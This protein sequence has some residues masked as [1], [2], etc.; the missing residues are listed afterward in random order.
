MGAVASAVSDVVGGAV[1]TV[2]DAVEDVGDFVVNEV[3]EPVVKTVDNTIQAALEDPVGT[4]VKVAAISTGNPAIIAAANA[5][6]AVAN[7]ASLEDAAKAGATGYVAGLVGQQVATNLSPEFTSQFENVAAGNAAAN[8]IGNAA[9]AAVSGRDPLAALITSGAGSAA[10]EIT[11][12]MEGFDQLSK[13]QQAAV[14][15]AIAK[16]LTGRDPSQNLIN[17]AI[18]AGIDA[19]DLE[20]FKNTGD[21]T[22]TTAAPSTDLVNQTINDPNAAPD[23]SFYESIGIDPATLS[24]PP[25]A[26]ED[27]LAFL[28]AS[29]YY[30][31]ITGQFIYDENGPLQAPLDN[32]SGTN[33]DSMDGYTYDKEKRTWVSP[34]GSVTDLS[35]LESSGKPLDIG[36]L[37]YMKQND[38]SLGTLAKSLLKDV[39]LSDLASYG[40]A[41]AGAL[42]FGSMLG[43]K[44]D[45]LQL[46]PWD[47]QNQNVNWNARQVEGPRDGVVYGQA[48]VTP[49][50]TSA[51]Q[52]GIMSLQ[53][54]ARGGD[55]MGISSL[56]GYAAGGNPRLLR[57]P[58]DGMS[59]NIPATISG[60]QPARLADG[61]FVVPADVVSH[62]GN[63]STEAGAKALYKM[64]EQV[65]RA[66]TGNPKQGKQINPNKFIPLKGK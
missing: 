6:V 66:R 5:A 59:D 40:A 34:D 31:E 32:T 36:S 37:D 12:G 43:S 13:S 53:R 61:E 17:E 20:R 38:P 54:Y 14:N 21:T 1:D 15:Q 29:G 2:G 49:E 56:G 7:G 11:K 41:G 27:P 58:G 22:Q 9:S 19:I 26:T 3:V 57:G 28:N 63:G 64:M 52:G 65:R 35:Y 62:L 45:G 24:N 25:A 16:T 10:A 47:I 8:A 23:Q 48:Q 55:V 46:T 18:A 42:T 39:A 51:A 44:D 60:K 30:D 50:F 33:L 4:A